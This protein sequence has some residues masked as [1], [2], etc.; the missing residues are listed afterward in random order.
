MVIMRILVT[1]ASGMLGQDIVN[2]FAD[3]GHEVVAT[4][5]AD[6]DITNPEAVE[7]TIA[8]I[9]PDAIIN[10]A[11]FNFVD[12][13]EDPAVF[14]LAYAINT[15]G[16][17]NLARA[18]SK[19]NIP[20]VHYSTD[21]VFAGDKPDGYVETDK[22]N[23]ISKYGKTKAAGEK[24]VQ[25]AGGKWYILRL[26]KIFG[27]PGASADSKESFVQMMLRLAK[28]KPVLK[29]VDEE[30]GAN[31][32]T[33]DIAQTTLEILTKNGPSGIYHVVNEGGGVTW[34]EFA[35][36]IFEIVGVTTPCEPVSSNEFP[37]RP[38]ARPKFARLLN[39]KLPKLRDRKDALREFLCPKN[40]FAPD[41]S[42]IIVSWNVRELLKNNLEKLF[43]LRAK[44]SFEVIVI[45]N[46]SHDESARMI[47][48]TF[49][50]VHLIQNDCNRGFAFAC[51][52][53]MRVAQGKVVILFNPDMFPSEN[54]FDHA[55]ETLTER[56]DIGVLG[57]KLVREDGSVIKSVRRDP[58]LIDQ[59]AILLKLPHFCRCFTR[60]YLA[61]DFDYETSREVEQ[62]RGSFF[63]FRKELTDQIGYLDEKNFFVWFE[64]VDFC[65]RVRSAGL[66]VWYSAQARCV[67]LIG[68]GF[69]Q[70]SVLIKQRRLSLSMAR[71]FKKWH[72]MW[73]ACIVYSLRPLAITL[74]ALVDFIG[75]RSRL[76]K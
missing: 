9:I 26:S 59:M 50:R 61:E 18:A 44:H 27:N 4:D 38:A 73:Q 71:Y 69:K 67:D 23:P 63:A 56:K 11:A 35:R 51:N 29:V 46:G 36:E 37:Q 28:E 55:Y 2:T 19:H 6:L 15:E 24:L 49:P 30:V 41:S 33:K 47:R 40:D 3:A 65:K 34:Y 60:R 54:A 25:A 72:P 45:D 53:G 48:E 68:Q 43:E 8:K 17:G 76:W 21:Y 64:E 42:I 16:P 13:I 14:P 22:P 10:T 20:F 31:S 39:T 52:Q 70:Q 32:Y 7:A 58:E 5:R 66:K 74:G 12:K 1:G 75:V 62:I 57:I